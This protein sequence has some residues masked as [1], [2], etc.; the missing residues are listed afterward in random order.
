MKLKFIYG[1]KEKFERNILVCNF[2]QVSL[3]GRAIL[4]LKLISLQFG[5]SFT[6]ICSN[7]FE[8][9]MG[10]EFVYNFGYLKI[11]M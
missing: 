10:R 8:I 6:R 4:E 9:K 2:E 5:R 11:S 7:E 1:S 3:R